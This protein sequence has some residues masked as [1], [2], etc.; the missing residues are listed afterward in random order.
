MMRH[1]GLDAQPLQDTRD[2]Q[3][4]G[5]FGSSEALRRCER[6]VFGVCAVIV[7]LLQ[8]GQGTPVLLPPKLRLGPSRF[9]R[10]VL[11]V[12]EAGG[13]SLGAVPAI[14]EIPGVRVV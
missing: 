10:C 8:V 11:G 3:I 6:S 7:V 4:F 13:V 2:S 5:V 1:L 14:E 9:C 12:R